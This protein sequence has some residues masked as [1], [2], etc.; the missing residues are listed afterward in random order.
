MFR[1]NEIEAI[2]FREFMAGNHHTQKQSPRTKNVRAMSMFFPVIT[3]S[4]F[5]PVYDTGF[6]LFFALFL[7]GS[8][9]IAGSALLQ[10]MTAK[11]GS[12]AISEVISSVSGF[13]FPVVSEA[14]GRTTTETKDSVPTEI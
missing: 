5:F 12:P 8:A 9:A 7:I 1:K 10:H 3:P 11:A 13:I 4:S 14:E 6:A 2:D